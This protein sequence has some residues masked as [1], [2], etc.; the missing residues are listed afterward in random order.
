MANLGLKESESIEHAMVTK[1][2]QRAQ[3]KLESNIQTEIKTESVK[4]WFDQNKPL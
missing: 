2:I 4:D 3:K 1:S